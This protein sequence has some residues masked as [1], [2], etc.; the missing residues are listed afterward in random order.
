MQNTKN[1]LT[2]GFSIALFIIC[3]FYLVLTSAGDG[4]LSLT[5]PDS[6]IYLQY[7]RNIASGHPY[8]Y[9]PGD[10]A[11]T[12]STSHFFPFL[13]AG[14]Y[15][16]GATGDAFITGTFV[17]NA[18]FYFSILLLVWLIAKKLYP[19]IEQTAFLMTIL[20]GHTL[21]AV[22]HLTDIG[23]FMLL[24]LGTLAS[25]LYSR[26]RL[27]IVMIILCALSRP[28]GFI[29]SIAFLLCGAAG[30][31]LNRKFK[32]APGSIEQS[33]QFIICGTIG[34][35]TFGFTLLLNH[36][37]TGQ[38]QF[39][40]ITNKGY[41]SNY[42][43]IGAVKST[44]NDLMALLKGFFLGLPEKSNPNRQ[45]FLFPAIG[46]LL[47]VTGVLLYPR[48]DKKTRLC[49]CWV[50]LSVGAV[51]LTIASSQW[52]WLPNDRYLAW[53][54]PL[55]IIYLLIGVEEVSKRLKGAYFKPILLTML[56]LFQLI[57][58]TFATAYSY[59]AA[60]QLNNEKAFA[61]RIATAIDPSK[62]IGST[63]GPYIQY[64]LPKHKI[65]NLYGITSP[66]FNEKSFDKQIFRVIEK[67]KHTPELQFQLWYCD[68]GFK[69]NA[70]W[71]APFIG[72]TVLQDTDAS[73]LGTDPK[74]VYEA[75]WTTLYG[76]ETPLTLTNQLA[77]LQLIS[78]LDISYVADETRHHYRNY[79][80]L[81]DTAFSQTIM[82]A[83]LGPIEYSEVGRIIVGS[84]SFSVN[85]V[86]PD[87]PIRMVLRTTD[88]IKGKCHFDTQVTNIRSM[89]LNRKLVL[90][91]FVDDQEV[92]TSPVLL[93]PGG[94]SEVFFD[95][96]AE[97]IKNDH[98]RITVVGDHVSFAYWFYQ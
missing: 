41:F 59:S 64:Y 36:L 20:S 46:G 10:T 60:V 38:F 74:A 47:A 37:L 66:A 21:L 35:L 9:A 89:K 49:E 40:S 97:Y 81:K 61:Q 30:L 62:E 34:T 78:K 56:I 76:G 39:M 95:I 14:I 58:L 45:F 28:E 42:P 55:W 63:A 13:L 77:H 24:A 69:E 15:K 65:L 71:P 1:F 98:P 50:L 72:K 90:R 87:K 82:T 8:I 43:V 52:Q 27:S 3:G 92:P 23:F 7:A 44:L 57:S 54:H 18:L 96:P 48:Q 93:S 67:I 51:I 33:K 94:F 2:L 11:S 26:F 85:N 19:G 5:E 86:S 17:L 6:A 53:L 75:K 12:G 68:K 83:K 80:R 70:P 29:F 22:M 32:N 84:E 4:A 91:L 31:M 79:V 73:I 25:I 88:S 16:L